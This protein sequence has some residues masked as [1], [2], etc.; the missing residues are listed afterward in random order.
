MNQQLNTDWKKFEYLT[1]SETVTNNLPY[2]SQQHPD[3]WNK[4]LRMLE[5][6]LLLPSF[7]KLNKN[8]RLIWTM[9]QSRIS[10]RKKN[11][12][13]CLLHDL[14]LLANCNNSKVI[15]GRITY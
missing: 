1:S 3:A 6:S 2:N 9:C 5:T 10:G 12:N 8:L 7:H 14:D 11:N 15:Y 13:N 4:T